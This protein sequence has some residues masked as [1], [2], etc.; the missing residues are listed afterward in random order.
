MR[1]GENMSKVVEAVYE[2][3]VLYK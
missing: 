2:N 3:G 1:R